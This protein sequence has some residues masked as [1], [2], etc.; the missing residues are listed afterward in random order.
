MHWNEVCSKRIWAWPT[1]YG[2][3]ALGRSR[4]SSELEA[5][6]VY[7][8]NSRQP[9]WIMRLFPKKKKESGPEG[10]LWFSG[11]LIAGC[12]LWSKVRRTV[13]P[14]DVPHGILGV[15]SAIESGAYTSYTLHLL[16]RLVIWLFNWPS[17][18][19]NLYSCN[20]IQVDL[21]AV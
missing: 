3:S 7:I 14:A 15:L 8:G 12:E 2:V 18:N 21:K 4:Q 16:I 13:G 1:S 20:H 5:S 11:D 19:C 9:D 17:I 10:V 6:S